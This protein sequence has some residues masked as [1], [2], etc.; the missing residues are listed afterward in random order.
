MEDFYEALVRH[1]KTPKDYL[2]DVGLFLGGIIGA[3]AVFF[4]AGLMRFHV[5]GVVGA[6]AVLFFALQQIAFHKWEYEYII[7]Q[8][9][10]D[11]DQVIAQRKRKRIVSFDARDCE[12][13]APQNRGNYFDAYKD[14]PITDCTAYLTNE[15]N[16][17]AVLERAGVRKC[18]LF[19]PSED[20]VQSLKRYNPRNTFIDSF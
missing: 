9:I 7:T 2:I 10:V 3:V 11:I 4:I 12:I 5:I 6:G 16:Y 14:L 19:Q 13:I 1:I 20:M 15:N 8:G 18:I 17:F